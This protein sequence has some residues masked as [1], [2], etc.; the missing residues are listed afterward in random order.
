MD[1][2]HMNQRMEIQK[3]RGIK[4]ISQSRTNL[5]ARYQMLNESID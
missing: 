2:P 3:E 1:V 4:E 5:L